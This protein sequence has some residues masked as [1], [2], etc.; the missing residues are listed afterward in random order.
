M[1]SVEEYASAWKKEGAE[2]DFC[3]ASCLHLGLLQECGPAVAGAPS[4]QLEALEGSGQCQGLVGT[5][6]GWGQ[7]LPALR[8][9]CKLLLEKHS[10]SGLQ[11]G[12][13]P[14]ALFAPELLLAV[15]FHRALAQRKALCSELLSAQAVGSV[16]LVGPAALLHC[17]PGSSELPC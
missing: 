10:S 1:W 2:K 17:L 15:I 6:T 13:K 4:A 9:C 16:A 12:L 3:C 7:L 8:G 11:H 14:S 5:G